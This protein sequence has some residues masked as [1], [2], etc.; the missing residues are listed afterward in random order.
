MSVATTWSP[1]FAAGGPISLVPFPLF[2]SACAS[3]DV[4]DRSFD[5]HV[6]AGLQVHG[7][8]CLDLNVNIRLHLNASGGMNFQLALAVNADAVVRTLDDD[9]I[10]SGLVDDLNFF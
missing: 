9:A 4:D 10:I 1:C 8:A 3:V 7:C 5:R 2:Q 6:G